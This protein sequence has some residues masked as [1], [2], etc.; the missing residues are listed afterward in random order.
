[1]CE[2][3]WACSGGG[4][5][6]GFFDPGFLITMLVFG[7]AIYAITRFNGWREKYPGGLTGYLEGK[8]PYERS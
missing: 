3:Y 5:G 2:A 1:M 7:G 4:G 8:K 6:G